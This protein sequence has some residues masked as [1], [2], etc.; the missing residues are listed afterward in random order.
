MRNYTAF[1]GT[2]S[3]RNS[4][5]LYTIT[6][7]FETLIPTISSTTSSY[8]SGALKI[9][10]DNKYLYVTQEGMTFAGF[11]NGGVV[12]YKIN[13]DFSLSLLNGLPSKGQRPCSICV[14]RDN[15]NLYVVN[16]FGG[17][18]AHF[19]IN[20]DGS[21]NKLEQTFV[22]PKP[23]E[24]LHAIHWVDMLNDD[25][26]V[27]IM[28]V[29]TS[30]FEILNSDTK[31]KIAQYKFGEKVFVRT[32]TCYGKYIYAMLQK[33]GDIY[34]FENS[35]DGKILNKKQVISSNINFKSENNREDFGTSSIRITP[36][37]K[38]LFAGIR[39]S[40]SLSVFSINEEGFLK[41]ENSIALPGE[42]PRDFNISSD[43][44]IVITAL[45]QTDEICIHKINYETK[46]L[47][48]ISK[49]SIPS[50]A[51]IDII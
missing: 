40:N 8:N 47:E 42:C 43:G 1:V 38:L 39:N 27:G 34:V 19:S 31:E 51:A 9:S 16:F 15:K 28:S 41:M 46:D 33:S 29:A 35:V 32:F 17:S 10:S 21:L 2:N 25:K 12:A 23:K 20:K 44:N 49:I 48:Y 45:Q 24:W 4:K 30:S 18:L 22:E 3:T 7:D 26:H 6:I 14:D 36:N 11:A 5:G 37:G 13:E 50:P